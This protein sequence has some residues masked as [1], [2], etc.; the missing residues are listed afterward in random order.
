MHERLADE[1]NTFHDTLVENLR[2]Q[3]ILLPKF[4]VSGDPKLDK[5]LQEINMKLCINDA[6]VLR[7][8]FDIREDVAKDAKEILD[9]MSGYMGA[10]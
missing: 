10:V 8:D 7:H 9:K 1:D 4:N 5:L 6:D 2:E 3:A